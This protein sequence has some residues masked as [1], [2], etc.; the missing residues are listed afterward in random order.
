MMIKLYSQSDAKYLFDYYSPKVIGKPLTPEPVS[1]ITHLQIIEYADGNYQ[2]V[3]IGSEVYPG[4]VKPLSN[5]STVTKR[6]GL[7]SPEEVLESK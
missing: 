3:A 2:L 1:N 6:L 7:P 4:T 5:I